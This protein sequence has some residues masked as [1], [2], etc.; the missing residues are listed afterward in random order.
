MVFFGLQQN[1]E[2]LRKILE[3]IIRRKLNLEKYINIISNVL[4]NGLKIIIS[5]LSLIGI[6]NLSFSLGDRNQES[7]SMFEICMRKTRC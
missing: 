7:A 4:L 1:R 6:E 2:N 5:F 3:T